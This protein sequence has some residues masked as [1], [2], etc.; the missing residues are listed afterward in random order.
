M[1][2]T[3]LGVGKTY[4]WSCIATSLN[5]VNPKYE[6][7]AKGG[8]VKTNAAPAPVTVGDSALWSSLFAAVIMIAA[9]F[10]Y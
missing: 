5:P 2:F 8:D 1:K 3:G 6:T 10:F 9:V 4:K 7:E